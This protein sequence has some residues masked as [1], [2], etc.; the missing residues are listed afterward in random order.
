MKTFALLTACAFAS[1]LI[2]QE[3]PAPAVGL[4]PVPPSVAA[5]RASRLAERM[6]E[7]KAAKPER[8]PKEPGEGLSAVLE[9]LEMRRVERREVSR[10]FAGG[11][12]VRKWD[13]G[14]ET[15]EPVKRLTVP[16][17]AEDAVVLSRAKA[18]ALR[19][20]ADAGRSRLAK[21]KTASEAELLALGMEDRMDTGG[22]A[23]GVIAGL[24]AGIGAGRLA[25]KS[26][27]RPAS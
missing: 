18:E 14:T 22:A 1:I 10:K 24:L 2:A 27:R 4:P 9:R 5:E 17:A 7:R 25:K 15:D 20:V 21:G 12:I 6:L 13:D 8:A 3:P 16:K 26:S 19:S 23:G 11:R